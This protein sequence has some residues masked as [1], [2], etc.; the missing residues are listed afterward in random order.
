MKHYFRFFTQGNRVLDFL[1]H[2]GIFFLIVM[3]ID[4]LD[5]NVHLH[6]DSII[7]K[8]NI[9]TYCIASDKIN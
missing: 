7:D 9:N 5:L 3:N 4:V 1:I 2:I 6:I 8:R